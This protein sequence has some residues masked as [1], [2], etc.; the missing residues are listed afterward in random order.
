MVLEGDGLFQVFLSLDSEIEVWVSD[1]FD[2]GV[3]EG[4]ELM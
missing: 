4:A 1:P 2:F 3:H